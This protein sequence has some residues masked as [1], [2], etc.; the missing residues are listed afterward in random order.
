[1]HHRNKQYYIYVS[2]LSLL[3]GEYIDEMFT[4]VAISSIFVGICALMKRSVSTYI[5]PICDSF[6]HVNTFVC[7]LR[8]KVHCAY[9]NCFLSSSICLKTWRFPSQIAACFRYAG[10]NSSSWP[11]TALPV[12]LLRIFFPCLARSIKTGGDLCAFALGNQQVSK[13]SQKKTLRLRVSVCLIFG[14]QVRRVSPS[15]QF[16]D[17]S[18]NITSNIIFRHLWKFKDS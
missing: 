2:C 9:R 8:L 15:F 17:D 11:M 13:N 16:L 18:S 12:Q 1:M 6:K 5:M 14:R 4:S 10:A 7:V 3:R